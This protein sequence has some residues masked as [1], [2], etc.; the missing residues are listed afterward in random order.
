ML[1]MIY[2]NQ[3]SSSNIVHVYSM[4][5]HTYYVYHSQCSDINTHA[6]EQAYTHTH[7][8]IHTQKY[9]HT[10]GCR[11]KEALGALAPTKLTNAH[12]NLVFHNR[13]V[14]LVHWAPHN[15]E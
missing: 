5:V 7:T 4:Y 3:H 15:F 1:V 8:Y 13:N 14:S 2:V 11:T 12:R 6:H 10:T 9:I